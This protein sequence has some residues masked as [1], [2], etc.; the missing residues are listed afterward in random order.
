M[1]PALLRHLAIPFALSTAT[2]LSAHAAEP[3]PRIEI[4]AAGRYVAQDTGKIAHPAGKNATAEVAGIEHGR[5]V[6]HGNNLTLRYCSNVG[7]RFRAPGVQASHPVPITVEILHP[8][9][10][11]PNGPHERDAW[12]T[13]VDRRPRTLGVAFEEEAMMQPGAWTINILQNGRVLATQQFKLAVPPDLGPEPDDC[14]PKV[15]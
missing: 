3:A 4:M 12:Q 13:T 14:A 5:F 2:T 8:P 7:I 15:S 10:A 9:V 11:F 6:E 1:L